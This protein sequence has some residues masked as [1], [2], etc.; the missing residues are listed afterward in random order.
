MNT[1]ASFLS[2]MAALALIVVG[3]WYMFDPKKAGAVLKRLVI[4]L[5][6]FPFGISFL[7]QFIRGWLGGFTS[8]L[9]LLVASVVA[10]F[11]W[12]NR[13]HPHEREQKAP[14]PERTPVLPSGE[15]NE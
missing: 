8:L 15:E 5:L 7:C 10:Y 6:L 1:V 3:F 12:Q 4:G 11:V 14:R 9:L 2:S 13:S